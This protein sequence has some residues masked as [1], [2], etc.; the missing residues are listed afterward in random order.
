MIGISRFVAGPR[1]ATPGDRRALTQHMI[2]EPSP[3]RF[4]NTSNRSWSRMSIARRHLRAGSSPSLNRSPFPASWRFILIPWA[5]SSPYSNRSMREQSLPKCGVRGPRW[6]Y[7]GIQS[8]RVPAGHADHR[9]ASRHRRRIPG[10]AVQEHDP[11][12]H[13][14]QRAGR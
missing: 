5:R 3:N 4:L 13:G 2:G 12:A 1:N 14:R 7:P 8:D 10:I 6:P 9:N 11:A